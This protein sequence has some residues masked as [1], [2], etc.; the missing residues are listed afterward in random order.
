MTG[1]RD[2][3]LEWRGRREVTGGCYKTGPVCLV[4]RQD[5]RGRP[6][7]G[8][9][10]PRRAGGRAAGGATQKGR[11]YFLSVAPSHPTVII[12]LIT[13]PFWGCERETAGDVMSG[14]ATVQNVLL[15]LIS[16]L[17]AA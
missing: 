17:P 5:R 11:L 9:G 4:T 1:S 13:L 6:K 8:F 3:A 10:L 2:N 16:L 12:P 7:T 14:I 15:E